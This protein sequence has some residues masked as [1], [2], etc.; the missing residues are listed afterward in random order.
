MN[1]EEFGTWNIK[2]VVAKRSVVAGTII[3]KESIAR[4]RSLLLNQ[5]W[6]NHYK[7]SLANAQI[8]KTPPLAIN[9][10]RPHANE[11]IE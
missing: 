8:L 1:K 3:D 10:D 11:T 2:K 9:R 4:C 7:S 5:R 6:I